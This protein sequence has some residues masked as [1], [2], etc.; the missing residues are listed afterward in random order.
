MM[1]N[2]NLYL[3]L[4][5]ALLLFWIFK[6][7]F[8]MNIFVDSDKN[9]E[10]IIKNLKLPQR[11]WRKR[12]QDPGHCRVRFVQNRIALA[13][14]IYF[15]VI[16]R[17]FKSFDSDPDSVSYCLDVFIVLCFESYSSCLHIFVVV[18]ELSVESSFTDM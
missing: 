1:E 4:L 2:Y 3:D 15:P 5:Y 12:F 16:R 13:P 6:I 7:R 10:L 14:F 9:I 17:S 18:N 11:L 8:I